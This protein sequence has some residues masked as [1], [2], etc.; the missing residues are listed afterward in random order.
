M[1]GN[2]MT[3]FSISGPRCFEIN[4]ARKLRKSLH[5]Y[6]M[7][8]QTWSGLYVVLLGALA[9]GAYSLVG[10]NKATRTGPD[11]PILER[12]SAAAS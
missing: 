5:M 12:L 6:S 9:R 3:V 10:D 1:V 11:A 8:G 2:L 7:H 4:P